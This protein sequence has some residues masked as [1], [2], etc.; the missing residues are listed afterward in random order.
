MNTNY[1]QHRPCSAMTWTLPYIIPLSSRALYSTLHSNL[2]PP[3]S[4]PCRVRGL[5]QCLFPPSPND[6]ALEELSPS[7]PT[8]GHPLLL[9][10][11]IPSS[12]FPHV[13]I[14]FC[15]PARTPAIYIVF[16]FLISARPLAMLLG[17]T[18]RTPGYR[19]VPTAGFT[20]A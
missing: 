1:I 18:V 17:T 11:H 16:C 8:T 7:L 19:R 14:I 6:V 3:K 9:G 20:D 4:P 13:H 2:R 15:T 5:L 12:C 10:L